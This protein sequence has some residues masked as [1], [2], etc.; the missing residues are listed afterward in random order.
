MLTELRI[1]NLAII[2]ELV[3]SFGPGL[4]VLTGE[5]GAGKSIIVDALN[6]VTGGRAD[7]HVV[8]SGARAAVVEA[9]FEKVSRA[10]I[11][12]A[13]ALGAETEEGAILLRR[14]TTA[15]GKSRAFVG[16]G[17]VPLSA[18]RDIGELLVDLH[19]QHQRRTLLK[20]GTHLAALD[21]F[22][23]VAPLRDEVSAACVRTREAAER[24]ER[25]QRGLESRAAKQELLRFQQRELASADPRQGEEAE[26]LQERSRLS[27]A[28][29]ISSLAAEVEELLAE[30]EASAMERI[31][32]ARR[33]LDEL[34]GLDPAC[35]S[36]AERLAEALYAI[37]DAAA[38]AR[39]RG[40]LEADPLRL[41]AV[42]SRLALL[43]ALGRKHGGGPDA[44]PG[45]RLRV[46]EEIARLDAD[47]ESVEGSRRALEEAAAVYVDLASRLSAT[48]HEAAQRLAR[49]LQSELSRLALDKASLRVLLAARR[50]ESGP[51]VWN[52]ET[53][54]LSTD[55]FDL[56]ELL[57]SANA[58]EEA[59]PL[60]R[61]ASGGELSRVMLALDV[62]LV[63]RG[64]PE[65]GFPATVV[66][67]EVD[68]GIGGRTAEAVGERLARLAVE[69]QVLCVTHLSQIA[70]RGAHHWRVL[71]RESSGRT[72]VSAELL[73]GEG[74]IEEIARMLAGRTVSESVRR[75]AGELLGLVSGKRRSA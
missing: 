14:E 1:R 2:D 41:D 23:G 75:H 42:E 36:L 37:E 21:S 60:A 43:Q 3:I 26:L 51:A 4:N 20:A 74:R 53:V 30:G 7:A 27:H 16:G 15:E 33:A 49:Q 71:K 5:T 62:L 34:A 67:D 48:R 58:G 9:M 8:R 66:F 69:K 18:L 22:A 52:G 35:A 65:A 31:G 13:E 70:C 50:E 12:T 11:A 17:G 40:G 54:A 44:L 45:H 10:A 73:D 29:R 38:G 72:L 24:L 55:G 68:S 47:E 6:L 25:A 28:A 59:R 32:R 63:S 57:F 56:V 39:I 19:G 64:K 46:E 61:I